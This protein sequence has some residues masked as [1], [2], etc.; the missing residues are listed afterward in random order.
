MNLYPPPSERDPEYKTYLTQYK[1][2]SKSIDTAST[3]RGY[4]DQMTQVIEK[5]PYFDHTAP[6]IM[7]SVVY[8]IATSQSHTPAF[9]KD[10]EKN[11]LDTIFAGYRTSKKSEEE[12]KKY[13]LIDA[14]RYWT[15]LQST[16]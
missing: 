8:L 14:A 1:N 4:G 10:K 13:L 15:R 9:D 7:A 16:D 3:S 6:K 5:I 12:K 2:A 11:L